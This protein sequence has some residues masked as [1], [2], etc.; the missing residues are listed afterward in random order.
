MEPKILA[1][2]KLGEKGASGYAD[3]DSDKYVRFV[4]ENDEVRVEAEFPKKDY[5][6]YRFF[7]EVMGKW[8]P[9][10]SFF[11]KP[12]VIKRLGASSIMRVAT[13]RG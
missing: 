12:S 8:D 5:R 4:V 9:H 2:E 6:D 10:A 3:L 1:I 11:I 13:R 7:A